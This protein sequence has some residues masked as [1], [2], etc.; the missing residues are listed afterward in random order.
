MSILELI[1]WGLAGLLALLSICVIGVNYSVAYLWLVRKEH[2]SLAPLLGGVAGLLAL[3]ICPLNST[4]SWAWLPLVLDLG[5]AY[6]LCGFLYAVIVLKAFS[7]RQNGSAASVPLC[8]MAR[9]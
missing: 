4:H 8:S 2:H 9:G 3:L 5:C 6:S 7:K 1:R